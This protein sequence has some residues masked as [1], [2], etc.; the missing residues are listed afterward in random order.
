[1]QTNRRFLGQSGSGTQTRLERHEDI[2]EY[3]ELSLKKRLDPDSKF[4]RDWYMIHC[5]RRNINFE[6]ELDRLLRIESAEL[7][8]LMDKPRSCG[9]FTKYIPGYSPELHLS[10][11]ETSDR[12]RSNRRWNLIWLLVGAALTAVAGVLGGWIVSLFQSNGN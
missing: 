3:I 12:D 4:R 11:Y 6:V 7:D 2:I 10:R 5:Y 9:L 8:D 1:M